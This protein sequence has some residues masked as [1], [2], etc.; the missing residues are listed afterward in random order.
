M[1]K[2][3]I[4]KQILKVRRNENSEKLLRLSE[5]ITEKLMF[6]DIYRNSG[7]IISYVSY[8]HEV[9]TINLINKS[10]DIGKKVLVPKV[11]GNEMLFHRINSISEL[12][13][14][15]LGILEPS[16]DNI[17]EPE[18]GIMIMPGAA[19]DRNRNRIGYGGGFY[20]R[21]IAGHGGL[22]KIALA[23]D[24]QI[25]PEIPAKAHDIRPD[26]IITES[27]IIL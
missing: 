18:D 9:D 13:P 4:R 14:S 17:I 1:T 5:I 24:F 2:Q 23:Y 7:N 6:M 16:N 20:D 21:Y 19:F 3:E 10:L 25:V 15:A 12:V 27:E 8:N 11:Y 26:L 22:Y